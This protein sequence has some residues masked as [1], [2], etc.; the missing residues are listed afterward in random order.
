[1]SGNFKIKHYT[2]NQNNI[3]QNITTQY[4]TVQDNTNLSDMLVMA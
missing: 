4:K 1:M 3:V 2:T